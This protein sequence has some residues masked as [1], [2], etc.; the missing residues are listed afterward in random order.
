VAYS[1]PDE[2]RE[3]IL[4]EQCNGDED[5]LKRRYGVPHARTRGEAYQAEA[6]QRTQHALISQLGNMSIIER[7]PTGNVEPFI[8]KTRHYITGKLTHA[9]K[10]D[11]VMALGIGLMAV[12][13][14]THQ[15]RGQGMVQ[16]ARPPTRAAGLRA[17]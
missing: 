15:G 8:Y 11:C 9:H 2:E 6:R 12:V 1:T 7:K 3:G 13:L 16:A 10:D 17:Y 14:D 4:L 5:E